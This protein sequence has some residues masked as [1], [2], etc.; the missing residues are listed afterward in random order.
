MH[1]AQINIARF[2]QPTDHPDNA[3]FVNAIDAVNAE[4][5]KAPGF[6]WRLEGD[7]D[8]GGAMDV[9]AFE[10][11]NMLINMSVW[12]SLDALSAFVYRHAAHRAIMRRRKEWFDETEFHLALWWVKAGDI[13]TVEEGVRRLKLL[14]ENG[15]TPEAFTFKESFPAP[16][17]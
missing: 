1:L 17:A 16:E 11:P 10:D 4:A 14:E 5:D 3:E 8:G 7:G 13:P 15:P 6:V 9:R 12:E 2:R